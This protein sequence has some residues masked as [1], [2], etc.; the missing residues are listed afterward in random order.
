MS[1]IKYISLNAFWFN[2]VAMARIGGTPSDW[3]E[4]KTKRKVY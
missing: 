4:V 1:W 3:G 2:T